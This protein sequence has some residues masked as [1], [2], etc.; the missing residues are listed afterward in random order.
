[1]DLS[2]LTRSDLSTDPLERLRQT[3]SQ[4]DSIF[5]TFINKVEVLGKD[6]EF[7]SYRKLVRRTLWHQRDHI[8]HIKE[9][10]FR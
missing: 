1:M 7:W 4:I 2:D 5:P 3:S 9:L 8:D 10:A 6:G